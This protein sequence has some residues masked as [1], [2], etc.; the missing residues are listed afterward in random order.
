MYSNSQLDCNVCSLVHMLTCVCCVAPQQRNVAEVC[1]NGQG[2]HSILVV[3]LLS[4]YMYGYIIVYAC[5]L[6]LP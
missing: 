2:E 1:Q 3:S 6:A 5:L 4:S